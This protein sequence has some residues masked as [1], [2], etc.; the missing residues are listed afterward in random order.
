LRAV[1]IVD[2]PLLQE[3]CV[4]T[5]RGHF[6]PPLA[7]RFIE[8]LQRLIRTSD[9]TDSAGPPALPIRANA[10]RAHLALA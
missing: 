2:P 7:A 4:V 10:R 5:L 3:L 9:A 6:L 1:Q 8:V